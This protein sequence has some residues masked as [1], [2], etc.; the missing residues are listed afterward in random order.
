MSARRKPAGT[1]D[2]QAGRLS[3]PGFNLDL[4]ARPPRLELR[5]SE[6]RRAPA[7][8]GAFIFCAN[9]EPAVSNPDTL[10]HVLN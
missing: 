2:P 5:Q 4:E 6:A 7:S 1:R 8:H 10:D 9:G 3:L